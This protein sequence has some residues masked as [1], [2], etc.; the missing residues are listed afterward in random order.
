MG[1]LLVCFDPDG[2][3]EELKQYEYDEEADVLGQGQF[4][5]VFRARHTPTGNEV[6]LK[7]MSKSTV[8]EHGMQEAL[9]EEVEILL[10]VD[11]PH[12]I[13]AYEFFE[14]DF[15]FYLST[16]LLLGGELFDRIVDIKRY[17]EKNA[18]DIFN[19]LLNTVSYLHDMDT[20]HRDIK[21]ENLLLVNAEDD[22][23]VKLADFG[24]AKRLHG[25][26]TDTACGTPGYIGPE[27]L[28]GEQY[29]IE[30]D[31]FSLGVV[32]YILLSGRPPFYDSNDRKRIKKNREVLY[33]FNKKYWR[34]VSDNAKDLIAKMLEKNPAKRITARKALQH[35]WMTESSVELEKRDIQRAMTELRRFNLKRKFRAI[36]RAAV[37][38][39]K[40][41][42][43]IEDLAA[44]FEADPNIRSMHEEKFK[45]SK[46]RAEKE[47]VEEEEDDDEEETR[48]AAA[49][50]KP[51]LMERLS[52]FGSKKA[53]AV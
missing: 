4:G 9:K 39:G 48:D 28:R 35:P 46:E 41:S 37:L 14:D 33:S 30:V 24:F 29:G 50:K 8:A 42:K 5:T 6:A 19:I 13:K 20:V 49:A 12:I 16:E 53:S 23:Q 32:L 45:A 17:S 51:S 18:R 15:D 7:V 26:K 10:K 38:S 11:H 40:L 1:N 47:A 31:I 2:R 22:T 34:R 3:C 36:V 43:M 21:P 25:Q 27:I 52:S 44:D